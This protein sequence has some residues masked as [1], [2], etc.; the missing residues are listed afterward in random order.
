MT[1][2][3]KLSLIYNA[4]QIDEEETSIIIKTKTEKGKTYTI[5][6]YRITIFGHYWTYLYDQRF[7]EKDT[8]IQRAA[9]RKLKSLIKR[10]DDDQEKK[11]WTK[12]KADSNWIENKDGTFTAK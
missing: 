2:S 11:F 10:K 12:V 7:C 9:Q 5:L 4:T 3:E 1:K 8:A 6:E